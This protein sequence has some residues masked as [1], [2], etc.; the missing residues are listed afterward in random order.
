MAP[1][2]FIARPCVV[3]F[4]RTA[5]EQAGAHLQTARTIPVPHGHTMTL[6][7]LFGGGEDNIRA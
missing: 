1:L 2:A 6:V 4:P 3:S 5:Y 7:E